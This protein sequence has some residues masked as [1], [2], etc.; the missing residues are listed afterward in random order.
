LRATR[1]EFLIGSIEELPD[2]LKKLLR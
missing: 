2:V 1:P